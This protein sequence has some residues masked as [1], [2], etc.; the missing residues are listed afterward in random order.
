MQTMRERALV[1]KWHQADATEISGRTS[2]AGIAK[3]KL[4][5]RDYRDTTGKQREDHENRKQ[6]DGNDTGKNG[7]GPDPKA[8]TNTRTNRQWY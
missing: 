5:E 8:V 6:M 2:N 3:K 7:A 1:I 4:R